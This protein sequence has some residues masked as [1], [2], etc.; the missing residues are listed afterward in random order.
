MKNPKRK[1]IVIIVLFMLT[2]TSF[3]Y[4]DTNSCIRQGIN[5]WEALFSGKFFWYY[6]L[7]IASQQRGEMIDVANYDM[8]LNFLM[9]IWQFPL[10]LLEKFFHINALDY[11]VFRI[12]GKLYLLILIF[13]SAD[14]LKKIAGIIIREPKKEECI[15]F[16][17][18][19]SACLFSATGVIGQ[20]D[21]IGIVF[22]LLTYHSIVKEEKVKALLFFII[23]C[24][25]KNFSLFIFI[26][27]IILLEKN[28]L[29]IAIYSILPLAA[30]WLINLPFKIVDAEATSLKAE[31]VSAMLS[32]MTE[33]KLRFMGIDIPVLFLVFIVICIVCYLISVSKE[34]V[35][36]YQWIFYVGFISIVMVQLC[37][38]T[39]PYWI[40]YLLPFISLFLF[41]K[42]VN[43]RW[44]TME[45]IASWFLIG[46]Q[47]IGFHW[48]YEYDVMFGMLIDHILPLK[49]FELHGLTMLYSFLKRETL[50]SVWTITYGVFVVWILLFL[51][52]NLPCFWEKIVNK[53]ESMNEEKEIEQIFW[54]RLF[55]N[56]LLTNISVVFFIIFVL[57]A[58][59]KKI[60]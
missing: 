6:S 33:L 28:L 21:I 14:I 16:F 47:L 36:Y 31:R 38:G 15:Y 39:S 46:G 11:F 17:Y 50:F 43:I 26:P 5:F 34:D 32:E 4:C 55:G 42:K 54:V 9:G 3:Y 40:I 19:S 22:I 29:K 49:K 52:V 56:Y 13:F 58:I 8:I 25:C 18:I 59:V 45:M 51:V 12:Y 24:Q 27:V 7:N 57:D 48:C 41:W 60:L 37:F 23:A 35:L 2:I 44:I 53:E 20:V 30:G 10:Y 1:K